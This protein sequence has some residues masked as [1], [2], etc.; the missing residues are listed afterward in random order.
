MSI[1]K[2]EMS[3]RSYST[4]EFEIEL[5]DDIQQIIE[6][7]IQHAEEPNY[8]DLK[9]LLPYDIQHDISVAARRAKP[10]RFEHHEIA[11]NFGFEVKQIKE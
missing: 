11:A 8:N 9:K 3:V 6:F 1:H 7:Y 10:D 4:I 2:F 5:D